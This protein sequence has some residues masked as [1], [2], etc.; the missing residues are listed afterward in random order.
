MLEFKGS[1]AQ[2][3]VYSIIALEYSSPSQVI[4]KED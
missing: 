4:V 1:L 2:I 3:H